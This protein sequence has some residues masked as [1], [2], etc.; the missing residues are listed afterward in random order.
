MDVCLNGNKSIRVYMVRI[1]VATSFCGVSVLSDW[2][3][4]LSLPY[5]W[6]IKIR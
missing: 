1:V 2:E 4:D 5:R 6:E 3:A